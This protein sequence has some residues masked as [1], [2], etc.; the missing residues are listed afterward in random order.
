MV[1]GEAG[2]W[3]AALGVKL[4]AGVSGLGRGRAE[5]S[6]GLPQGQG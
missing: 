3:E 4:K 6:L 5:G 2:S 1:R